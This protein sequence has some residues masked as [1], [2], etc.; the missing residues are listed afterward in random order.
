MDER[1]RRI[2]HVEERVA[3]RRD[4]AQ[5]VADHEQHVGIAHALREP[6][7]G[8][9]REVPDVG[10]RAV[11]DVVLPAPAGGDRERALGAPGGEGVVGLDAPRRAADDDERPLGAGEHLPGPLDVARD[12]DGRG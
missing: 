3:G 12:R 5:P 8:A 7:V 4:L 2:R 1:L 9:E 11:V 6:G 10:V